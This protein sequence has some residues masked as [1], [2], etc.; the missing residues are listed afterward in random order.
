[1]FFEIGKFP[2]FR[3]VGVFSTKND[4]FSKISKIAC[5]ILPFLAF[6]KWIKPKNEIGR[7]RIIGARFRRNESGRSK[8]TDNSRSK[9]TES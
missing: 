4:N 7:F 6:S 9:T 8:S 5:L 1:M 2:I 3:K